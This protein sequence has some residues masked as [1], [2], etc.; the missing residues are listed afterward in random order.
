MPSKNYNGNARPLGEPIKIKGGNLQGAIGGLEAKIAKLQPAQSLDTGMLQLPNGRVHVPKRVAAGTS[1]AC[2][3]GKIRVDTE[4]STDALRK[5][6]ID[7]GFLT[8]GGSTELIEHDNLT[9]TIG[10]FV[11]IQVLWT[12]NVIDGVLQAGGTMGVVTVSTGASIPDDT[13]PTHDSTSG[14][15]HIALGGWVSDNAEPPALPT[16]VWIKQGCGSIQL[17]FCPGQGFFF[18]RNNEVEA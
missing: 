1:N 8:G 5:Y 3:L 6:K 18:G 2:I 15:A 17:Y 11:W 4:N 9:A 13:I 16:P 14:V 12:A 10:H 7:S